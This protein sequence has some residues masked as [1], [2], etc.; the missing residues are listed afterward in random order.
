MKKVWILT[1]L[2]ALVISS[3]VMAHDA[4]KGEMVVSGTIAKLDTANRAMTVT[5]DKGTSWDIQWS[6]S[7]KVMGGELKEGAAV[8]LGYTESE[9]KHWATWIKVTEAKQ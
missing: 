3:A 2:A 1:F 7:T 9:S 6:D 4:K 8:K 5:D